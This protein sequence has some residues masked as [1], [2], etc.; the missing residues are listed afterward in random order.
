[1]EIRDPEPRVGKKG[2]RDPNKRRKS[3]WWHR[4]EEVRRAEG[5]WVYYGVAASTYV[6]QIKDGKLGGAEPFEF[7]ATCRNVHRK[8]EDSTTLYGDLYIRW[9]GGK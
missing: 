3:V 1:M 4:L 6:T 8:N 5:A 7:Q 9:M 2:P